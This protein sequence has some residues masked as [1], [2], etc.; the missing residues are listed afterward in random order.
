MRSLPKNFSTIITLIMILT[1]K[2]RYF[3]VTPITYNCGFSFQK[4]LSPVHIHFTTNRLVLTWGSSS[5]HSNWKNQYV[6]NTPCILHEYDM[7][8]HNISYSYAIKNFDCY[9]AMVTEVDLTHT[10]CR[11]GGRDWWSQTHT[12]M[13]HAQHP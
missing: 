7:Y 2:L 5:N 1:G 6:V 9:V 4:Y 13:S 11:Y 12:H 10:S 8:V 3:I